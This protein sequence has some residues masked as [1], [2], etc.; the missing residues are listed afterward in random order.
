MSRLFAKTLIGT[1]V[2][3]GALAGAWTIKREDDCRRLLSSIDPK[4]DV[5]VRRNS[6]GV[7]YGCRADGP[8]F[9]LMFRY[10]ASGDRVYAAG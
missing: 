3:G 9:D 1:L 2:V 4:T 7:C 6:A 8:L 5:Q 10:C